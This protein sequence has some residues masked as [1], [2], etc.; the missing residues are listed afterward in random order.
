MVELFFCYDLAC[1]DETHTCIADVTKVSVK[2]SDL[3]KFERILQNIVGWF[4][5]DCVHLLCSLCQVV[6]INLP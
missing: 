5:G 1:R 4:V 2:S 6:V 3:L